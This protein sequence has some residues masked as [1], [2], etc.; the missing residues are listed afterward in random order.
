MDAPVTDHTEAKPLTGWR[1][2]NLP[3]FSCEFWC[4]L[5]SL[6]YCAEACYA[7]DGMDLQGRPYP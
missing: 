6:G 1:A 3:E 2:A 7:V 5:V 4:P